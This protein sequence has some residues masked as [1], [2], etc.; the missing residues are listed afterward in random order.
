MNNFKE[1]YDK[2]TEI[3]HQ[4]FNKNKGCNWGKCEN[5]GVIP[6]LHKLNT[7]EV[8]EDKEKINKLKNNILTK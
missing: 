6:L 1:V 5:C 3:C 4:E 8:I 2:E 7:N